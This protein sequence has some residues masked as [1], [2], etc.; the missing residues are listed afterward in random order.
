MPMIHDPD[1]QQKIEAVDGERLPSY[2][3]PQERAQFDRVLADNPD[4]NVEHTICEIY[5]FGGF[6]R[7]FVYGDGRVVFS[8]LHSLRDEYTLRA[9]E[10]GF[11]IL[12][13]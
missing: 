4:L 9:I 10:E 8:H 6:H 3:L 1:L 13:L 11:E 12:G 7:W 2:R 5:S